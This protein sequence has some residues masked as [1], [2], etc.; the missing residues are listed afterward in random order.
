MNFFSVNIFSRLTSSATLASLGW[1]LTSI[2]PSIALADVELPSVDPTYVEIVEHNPDRDGGYVIGD[3]L[4]RTIDITIKSPYELVKESLPIVGYEHRYRGQISGIEL[5]QIDAQ[6]HTGLNQSSHTIHLAY[7]VFKAGRTAKP[8]ILR[9]EILKL[10]N[11]KTKELVQVRVPHFNFRTSPL[12]VYGEVNLKQ[13]MYPFI[14]PIKLK[15]DNEQ[16]YLKIAI[17]TLAISL[18]G[19]VYIFGA[20]TWLPKMGGPFAKAYRVINKQKEDDTGLKAS[21]ASLHKAIEQV[22][23]QSVFS[24]NLQI[25]LKQHPQYQPMSAELETFFLLSRQAY[26]DPQATPNLGK[27]P[28]AWLKTFCRQMRDCER[29]LKPATINPASRQ[30]N[31]AGANV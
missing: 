26:F 27:T 22:A 19:L 18:L 5:V 12:S 16:L 1:C 29:G 30:T 15:S 21:L 9:G 31:A 13:E 24:N 11:T 3:I 25:F 14:L 8:A 28:K 23:G 17:A 6:E 2:V 4:E 10:R 20:Y 7:Q